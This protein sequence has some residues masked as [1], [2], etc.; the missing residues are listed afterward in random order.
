MLH[1]ERRRPVMR[2]SVK[3]NNRHPVSAGKNTMDPLKQQLRTPPGRAVRCGPFRRRNQRYRRAGDG[4]LVAR[5]MLDFGKK[6]CKN[7]IDTQKG[8]A[9][10]CGH[11]EMAAMQITFPARMALKLSDT[12]TDIVASVMAVAN[13]GC[14]TLKACRR[15]TL[16]RLKIDQSFLSRLITSN[17]IHAAAAFLVLRPTWPSR[18]SLH[19][20]PTAPTPT[21]SSGFFRRNKTK[22]GGRVP[23]KVV[24]S[25]SGGM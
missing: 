8:R 9:R 12:H 2:L 4:R 19:H 6:S 13:F 1:W 22:K 3:I 5:G 14:V 24:D 18:V 15:Q 20:P 11:N 16:H 23:G 17:Q 25:R 10:G 21:N 7:D